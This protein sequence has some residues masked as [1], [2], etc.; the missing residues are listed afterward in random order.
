M[1]YKGRRVRA[2]N[3]LWASDFVNTLRGPL[4]RQAALALVQGACALLLAGAAAAQDYNAEARYG[5]K[6]LEGGFTPDPYTVELDAGGPDDAAHLGAKCSGYI[7]NE[8]PDYEVSYTPGGYKLGFFVE[9]AV[10]TTLAINDP[11]GAWHCEDDFNEAGGTNPG[12]VFDNPAAGK[13]DIWVGALSVDDNGADVRLII[14]ESGAPWGGGATGSTSISSGGIEFGDNASDYAHNGECDDPRFGGPGAAATLLESDRGRDASD[15]RALFERG[16]IALAV[17]DETEIEVQPERSAERGTTLVST[18]TGFYVSDRG[19][20]LTNNHVVEGCNRTTIQPMGASAVDADVISTNE[21]VDLALL[22]APVVPHARAAFRA[23]RSVRQGEEVVVFGF[24]LHGM[25]SSQGNL[26]NGL[27]TALSGFYDDLRVM[28]VSAPI[29]PGNSGGPV[30]DRGG[31]VVGVI[32]SGADSQFFMAEGRDLPQNVNFAIRDSLARSF[33]DTNNVDY[34]L[35]RTERTLSVAD[36]G[37]QAQDFTVLI[38]CY[39]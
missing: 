17:P 23:E 15:C 22:N 2:P 32:V 38:R 4:R 11:S 18:G 14:T 20:V 9:G 10:D 28:Q 39:Q 6:N 16:Q 26:T 34:E 13:Y 21:D 19:H 36:I 31:N 33:L 7:S 30:M 1:G 37:E 12:V 29:Q 3:D 24:P 35:A 25:L 5:S 27:V 8:K